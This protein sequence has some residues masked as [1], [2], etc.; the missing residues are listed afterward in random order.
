MKHIQYRVSRQS[1][2]IG[3]STSEANFQ[4]DVLPVARTGGYNTA[5]FIAHFPSLRC[6]VCSSG[7]DIFSKVVNCTWATMVQKWPQITRQEKV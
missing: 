7:T 1:D 3:K 6:Y 5:H 2:L 4:I